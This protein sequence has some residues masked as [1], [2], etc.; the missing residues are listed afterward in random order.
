MSAGPQFGKTEDRITYEDGRPADILRQTYRHGKVER[1]EHLQEETIKASTKSQAAAVVVS[2]IELLASGQ[3]SEL[4]FGIG[5]DNGT[6][7]G[8]RIVKRWKV[9]EER[10][11]H[12]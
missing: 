7:D 11:G 12:E 5:L 3:I 4:S 8:L 10:P 9:G 2:S 6:P 1:V